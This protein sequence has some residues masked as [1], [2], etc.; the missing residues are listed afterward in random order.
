MTREEINKKSDRELRKLARSKDPF[1]A[2]MAK[3]ELADRKMPTA[4]RDMLYL[5]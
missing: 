2:N 1:I 5:K 4:I 3:I